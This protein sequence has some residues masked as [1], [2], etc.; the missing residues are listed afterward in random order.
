L[1][2]VNYSTT[3]V[4][5]SF[6]LYFKIF[7]FESIKVGYIETIVGWNARA[8]PARDV[9]RRRRASALRRAHIRPPSVS[10]TA[11]GVPINKWENPLKTC[12]KPRSTTSRLNTR[13]MARATV[14]LTAHQG[15]PLKDPLERAPPRS[16]A[17]TS[18]GW[19][20][21]RS[22]EYAY[23]ERAPPRSRVRAALEQAPPR[24]R[25]LRTRTPVPLRG[26]GHLML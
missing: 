14:A 17:H 24:S 18:L 19:A 23:L 22:R 15:G 26:Y 8:R 1:E 10:G 3:F 11:L 20:L 21:P 13:G 12:K 2:R 16:R 5:G 25:A 9:A 7:E 4:F 6:E